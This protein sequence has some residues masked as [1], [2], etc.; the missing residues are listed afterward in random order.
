LNSKI[1]AENR[2]REPIYQRSQTILKQ[3]E[4]N[5]SKLKR[6]IEDQQSRKEP[7]PTFQPNLVTKKPLEE[8]NRIRSAKEFTSQLYAWQS[9]KQE[10]LQKEQ[11][12]TLTKEMEELTFKPKINKRSKE[13]AEKVLVI[14]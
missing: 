14:V 5:L 1:L 3:K 4:D 9:K 12:E 13:L 8:N 7:P 10:L 6:Q 2:I 11:Y